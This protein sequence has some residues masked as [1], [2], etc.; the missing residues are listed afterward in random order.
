MILH[1]EFLISGLWPVFIPPSLQK[2]ISLK[3]EDTKLRDL[4]AA[5]SSAT[6]QVVN[7][8]MANDKLVW[9]LNLLLDKPHKLASQASQSLL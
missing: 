9:M 4:N 5:N 3:L 2:E 1:V 6:S 8:N 7:S